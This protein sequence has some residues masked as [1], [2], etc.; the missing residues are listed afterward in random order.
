MLPFDLILSE[1]S[2]FDLRSPLVLV[3]VC[4]ITS[5]PRHLKYR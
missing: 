5:T 1:P 2:S 4:D 3:I